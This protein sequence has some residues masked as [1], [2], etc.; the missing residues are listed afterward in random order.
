MFQEF[1]DLVKNG[2]ESNFSEQNQDLYEKL[3]VKQSWLN[4]DPTEGKL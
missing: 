2:K 1:E 3:M 4:R